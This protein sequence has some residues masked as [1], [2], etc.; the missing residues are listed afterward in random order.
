MF[1]IEQNILGGHYDREGHKPIVI[2][3]HISVGSFSSV[4]NT[5][6]NLLN[7][8]SSTYLNGRDGRIMQFVELTKRPKTNG[9]I[10]S[11]KAPIVLQ[12]GALNPNFYSITIENEDA[13]NDDTPGVEGTLTEIQFLSLCW[14]HKWI[15][16]EV[17]RIYGHKIALNSSQVIGHFQIDSIGKSQ[18]PGPKFPWTRLYA[19]LAIADSMDLEHYEERID[20]LQKNTTDRVLAFA[21]YDRAFDLKS[22]LNDPKYGGAARAKLE[23]LLQA[24]IMLGKQATTAEEIFAVIKDLYNKANQGNFMGEAVR[25]LLVIAALAKE[26][27]L[28]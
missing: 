27:G 26:K 25:K 2:V 14:L 7:Q 18:C 8:K 24:L 12:M 13:Y 22:K 15:Q 10:R 23:S 17:L 4:K 6:Q 3:N 9:N 1:P 28:L 20:Y 11:P 19:E 21:F 5:F 16:T